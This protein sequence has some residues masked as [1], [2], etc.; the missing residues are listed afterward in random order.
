MGIKWPKIMSNTELR[1]AAGEKLIMTNWQWI[2][3]SLKKAD[4]STENEH[5]IAAGSQKE[6]KTTANVE[7]D[8]SE[9]SRKMQQNMRQGYVIGRQ[10]T[11]IEMLH[12]CPMFQ[13]K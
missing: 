13:M 3:Y 2:G 4:E 12:M 6:R 9:G 11:L 1:E 10:K 8:H 7:M 5:C